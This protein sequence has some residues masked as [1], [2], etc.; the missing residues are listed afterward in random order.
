MSCR[1]LLE[2]TEQQHLKLLLLLDDLQLV[3]CIKG[4]S[5]YWW[6]QQTTLLVA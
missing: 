5:N 6:L 4:L 1:Q 3:G 2:K